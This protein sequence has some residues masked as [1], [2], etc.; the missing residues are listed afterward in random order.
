VTLL[1]SAVFFLWFAL[2]STVLGLAFLPG[3][4]LPRKVTVWMSRRWSAL[5]FWG[6]RVIAGVRFEVRGMP[7]S[8]AAL[9]AAKHMSMWDTMALYLVLDDPAVVLKRGLQ[10]V[11]FYGWYVTKAGSIS[12]DRH[13]GASTLRKMTASAKRALDAGRSILIFPEGTRKKPGAAPDYKPGVAA[14]Y[15]Q[16]GVPCV[17]AALNSGLFWTG[18]RK[19][20]GN[21]VL[22]FL[23]PIPPGLRSRD[24]MKVLQD[25]LE[26]AT[27]D[28]VAEGRDLQERRNKL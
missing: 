28:L 14:L 13:G 9:V 17:P 3:L 8:S 25:R 4:I 24:F 10:F 1:R 12:V 15:S 7:P 11:P 18:F 19:R 6:L 5:N 27:N 23:E 16:L 26:T 21:I 22:E 2:V 20:S